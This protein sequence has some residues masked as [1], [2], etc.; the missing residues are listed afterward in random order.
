MKQ[1]FRKYNEPNYE[2]IER[3][4]EKRKERN[5]DDDV[6]IEYIKSQG[7]YVLEST[8]K[9]NDKYYYVQF[10]SDLERFLQK[11]SESDFDYLSLPL[12]EPLDVGDWETMLIDTELEGFRIY[13]D[14][15]F[16]Y[17]TSLLSKYVQ[18]LCTEI[19]RLRM[20]YGEEVWQPVNVS[21][22]DLEKVRKM[23]EATR[24]QK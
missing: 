2:L 19:Y 6:K 7:Y 10:E 14:R 16:K 4:I 22:E 5:P 13:E 18:V 23:Y 17:R 3:Y 8:D 24:E 12:T 20:T 11:K 15:E 21:N 9:N 1:I